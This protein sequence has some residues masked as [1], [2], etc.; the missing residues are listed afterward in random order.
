[1]IKNNIKKFYVMSVFSGFVLFYAIDKILME[2]RGLSLTDM[3]IIEVTYVIGLLLLEVPSGALADRWSRKYM[4][5]LNYIFFIAHAIIFAVAPNFSVFLLGTFIASLHSV[6]ISG[7]FNS[8]VYDSLKQIKKE[9]TYERVLGKIF[10]YTAISAA[11]AHIFGSM[12]AEYT[13]LSLPFW[14]TTIFTFVALLI[15][16]TLK[17]P[18]IHRTTGEISYW[19]HIRDTG[20][21]LW[22][23][24]Y[25][26]HIVFLA[27]VLLT[28][29]NFIDEFAQIYFLKIG[30]PIFFLGYLAAVA[31]GVESIG[32]K[33][34][35]RLKKM[36]R[37]DLYTV[38]LLI[39]TLG[40]LAM[41]YLQSF[42]GIIFVF[43]PL[44]ITYL[45]YTLLSGDLH[46]HLPSSQRATG[47]SYVEL[48]R[49]LFIVPVAFAFG[50]VADQY[51][52]FSAYTLLGGLSLAYLL[53][54]IISPKKKL[55]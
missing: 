32:A 1:M 37:Y 14:I 18:N 10:F 2:S 21:Y 44:F 43:V 52:I 9:G 31:S 8:I 45:A 38:L 51:S 15:S 26:Y 27:V 41:G 54:F 55:N 20:R 7:T 29:S 40:L 49:A 11:V 39:N 17:E 25:L 53:F 48:L 28:I 13:N 42:I 6:F 30:I 4:I 19:K 50:F 35:H 23:H 47:E 5:S 24:P 46:R 34:A 12:L 16:L 3:V 22:K 33:I 36:N